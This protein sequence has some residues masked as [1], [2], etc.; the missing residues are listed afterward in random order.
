MGNWQIYVTFLCCGEFAKNSIGIKQQKF[1][2]NANKA[3]AK[4]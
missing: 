3:E 4:F 1:K 2:P